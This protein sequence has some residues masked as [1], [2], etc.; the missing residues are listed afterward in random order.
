MLTSQ[1]HIYLGFDLKNIKRQKKKKN[2][3]NKRQKD[4][5][6]TIEFVKKTIEIGLGIFTFEKQKTIRKL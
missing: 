5:L 6:L 1:S 4:L 3:I 2:R